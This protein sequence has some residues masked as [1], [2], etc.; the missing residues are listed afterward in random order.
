VQANL[1]PPE[2][3]DD[4]VREAQDKLFIHTVAKQLRE[5]DLALEPKGT[6]SSS[7]TWIRKVVEEVDA[8]IENSP[9]KN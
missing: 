4:L 9:F 5:D 1:P 8:K 7:T 2:P 6:A 3:P